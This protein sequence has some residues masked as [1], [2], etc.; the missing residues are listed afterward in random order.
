MLLN[1]GLKP[2]NCPSRDKYGCKI[3]PNY[4]QSTDRNVFQPYAFERL[5]WKDLELV[6]LLVVLFQNS[7]LVT[8]LADIQSEFAV[9]LMI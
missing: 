8:H 5:Y 3:V 6:L 7:L 4:N 2:T 9:P 1:F